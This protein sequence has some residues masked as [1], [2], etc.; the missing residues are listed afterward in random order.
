VLQ[1]IAIATTEET[2]GPRALTSPNV[3]FADP[4]D[5]AFAIKTAFHARQTILESCHQGHVLANSSAA[6]SGYSREQARADFEDDLDYARSRLEGMIRDQ[7]TAALGICEA[8]GIT[9]ILD[10][11]RVQVEVHVNSGPMSP[12]EQKEI[13]EQWEKGAI[14]QETMLARL[15]VE[16]VA[17]EVQRLKAAE[18]ARLALLT[19]RAEALRAFTDAGLHWEAAM[20]LVGFTAAEVATAINTPSSTQP[21]DAEDFPGRQSRNA[22]EDDEEGEGE[23]PELEGVAA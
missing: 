22:P 17:A 12:E 21:D 18:E 11:F 5:P 9:G 4:V 7:L 2:N 6:P 16:D 8:M 3:I 19:K 20:L 10:R 23:I 15:G 1:P 13:R 14:S